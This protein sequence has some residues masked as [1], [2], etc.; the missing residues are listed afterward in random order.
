MTDAE[1]DQEFAYTT[2]EQSCRDPYPPD[3]ECRRQR[4]HDGDHAA[5][6]GDARVR[7]EQ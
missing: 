5:G 3:L 2:W 7:W 1:L 4:G 6:Y